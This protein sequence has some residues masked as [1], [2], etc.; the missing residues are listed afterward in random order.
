MTDIASNSMRIHHMTTGI[1]S[2]KAEEGGHMT[3]YYA[4]DKKRGIT[5]NMAGETLFVSNKAILEDIIDKAKGIVPSLDIED[6]DIC[7]IKVCA[8]HEPMYVI[9]KPETDIFDSNND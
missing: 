6:Y 3:L 8:L 9:E 2:D 4:K 1:V 7:S 5:V